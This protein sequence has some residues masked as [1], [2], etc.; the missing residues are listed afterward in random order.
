MST[1]RAILEVQGALD[2]AVIAARPAGRGDRE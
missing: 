2:T 1:L